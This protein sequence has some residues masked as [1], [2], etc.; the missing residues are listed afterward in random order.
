MSSKIVSKS[1]L[2]FYSPYENAWSKLQKN[3]HLMF[4]NFLFFENRAVYEIIL[5]NMVQLERSQMTIWRM[6]N[7]F[8]IPKATNRLSE[9]VL[10]IAFLLQQRL[11]ERTSKLS[12]TY[13]ACLV[14]F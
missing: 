5:K 14:V 6:R 7:A 3:T 13:I 9:Y 10:L 1:L 2:V 11:S 8:W 12:Y 4:N